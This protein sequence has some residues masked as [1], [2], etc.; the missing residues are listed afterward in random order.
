M[1]YRAQRLLLPS[2]PGFSVPSPVPSRKDGPECAWMVPRVCHRFR[3]RFARKNPGAV[4]RGPRYPPPGPHQYPA[5]VRQT[6]SFGVCGRPRLGTTITL[7]L[8]R[9]PRLPLPPS[10]GGPAFLLASPRSAAAP[11]SFV[12]AVR[13]RCAVGRMCRRA[14]VPP[15]PGP[16]G[17]VPSQ[18]SGGL[19]PPPTDVGHPRG[20]GASGATGCPPSERR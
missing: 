7:L 15:R 12:P 4:R 3:P 1:T 11:A 17:C 8:S 16:V 2:T 19:E 10:L 18:A 6:H 20:R 13:K 14:D 9:A 5:W